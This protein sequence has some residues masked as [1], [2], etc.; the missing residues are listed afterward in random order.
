MAL[1]I[2][3]ISNAQKVYF[4]YLQSENQQPFYAR[5]GDKVY[6]SSSG[7]YL[8]LSKLRDSTYS[9]NIGIEGGQLPEQLY[10]ITVNK[11]DQGYL[12]KNFPGKGWGLFNFQTLAVLNPVQS[13]PVPVVKTEKRESNSFTDLL[14]KAA[15]DSTLKEKPVIEKLEDKAKVISIIEKPDTV[16]AKPV[17]TEKIETPVEKKKEKVTA[18]VDS[19]VKKEIPKTEILVEKKIEPKIEDSIPVKLV[20]KEE[21]IDSNITQNT[22]IKS[23]EK[24]KDEEY[25]KSTVIKRTESSTTAGLGITF[26]DT[27]QGGQIDTIRIL[28]PN[29]KQKIVVPEKKDEEKKFLDKISTDSSWVNSN[30][31]TNSNLPAIQKSSDISTHA[32]DKSN[33]CSQVALEDDFFKL[34]KK[35][36]SESSDDNMIN[37]AK[38]GF[39]I[40]C[41]NTEQIK[42][43]STLFLT[44]EG[45]YKFFDA[46]YSYVSDMPN[47]SSLQS[48]LKSEYFLNRFKAMIH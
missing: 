12:L 21:I 36:A 48:E 40:K 23:E 7:G 1:T 24:P 5:M 26:L 33:N 31:K 28:I 37:E 8:I 38:K 11:K 29:E 3:T 22:N 9:M 13:N 20:I 35:M 30:T 2:Y 4:I 47:F 27:Y 17:E 42:N 45:K 14:A 16:A 25:K 10:S 41:Y 39:K 19:V 32:T 43:L 46:A 15:D 44:E 18:N 6:N 34:R